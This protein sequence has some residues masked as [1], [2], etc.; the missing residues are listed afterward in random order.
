MGCGRMRSLLCLTVGL[1]YLQLVASTPSAVDRLREAKQALEYVSRVESSKCGGG[2]EETL[3][4]AFNHTAWITYTDPAIRTANYL[5]KV[6]VMDDNTLNRFDDAMFYSFVRNN[7]H[8]DS[9]IFGSA[10]ALEP[11]VYDKYARYCPYAHKKQDSVV[12]FDIAVRY[13][14]LSNSTE[15]YHGVR[16]KDFSNASVHIDT[17]TFNSSDP[18]QNEVPIR[19][20]VARYEDGR[21]TYPYY[22][23][24]GGDIWM[25]TYSAPIFAV[26]STNATVFKGVATI[27][28]ELTNIDINQ[29]DASDHDS[30][31]ALDVF[32]GTHNCQPTTQCKPL[33]GEGFRRG[34]YECA[35]EE[36][37][38][39]PNT[40]S[41]AS[42]YSGYDIESFIDFNNESS[43]V[44]RFQCLR[45]PRGCETC[46]DDTPC[47]YPYNVPLRVVV[48]LVIAFIIAGCAIVAIV[49]HKNRNEMVIKTAS[50][51]FLHLM[52]LGAV[53]M[54]CHGFV[55]YGEPSD[56]SCTIEIWPFH[57]GFSV[58]YGAL[59]LK[60]WRISVIFSVGSMKRI[61]LPDK[62]LLHRL[63][64]I[65]VVVVV[66]LSCWTA[67]EPPRAVTIT[68]SNSLKFFHCGPTWWM[69]AIYGAEALLLLFGVYLCF[70]VR[71]APAHFNESKHITWSTYNAIILGSFILILNQFIVVSAGPDIVYL[72]LMAKLQALVT[73]TMA[74]IFA[75]KFWALY[76]GID[77]QDGG[78]V[79]VPQATTITGRVKMSVPTV[80]Q[81]QVERRSVGVQVM[82]DEVYIGI[83]GPVNINNTQL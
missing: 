73:I 25:V 12:A 24:G 80:S 8:G 22:D 49:I 77:L 44:P 13:N 59:I 82:P 31:G 6:L 32:R 79:G 51:L 29:C 69:F 75:P 62:S 74:L 65:V 42:A 58:M 72:L 23:C 55:L 21:W 7:V 35:C 5:S 45:C 16:V 38:Y 20:P 19:Q 4:L 64:P 18:S 53:I 26:N 40:S 17:V 54:C 81:M 30:S 56:V 76:R 28:I 67:I 11:G 52:C 43:I 9:L 48:L 63:V 83:V 47:L 78:S 41:A 14:Y 39:F 57:C 50:P 71:K 37:Y 66:Y 34:A 68:A 70:T 15:W 27:D 36:G 46:V 2:T 3:T 33:I 1:L 10:I 60:T 61:S